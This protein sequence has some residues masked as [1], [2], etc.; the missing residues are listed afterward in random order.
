MAQGIFYKGVLFSEYTDLDTLKADLQNEN[1]AY[2]TH[3]A[4]SKKTGKPFT[5]V[6]EEITIKAKFTK[7][8]NLA[9]MLSS[10]V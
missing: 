7:G 8:S 6:E 4:I 3:E 1:K 5:I 9:N 10:L 2:S